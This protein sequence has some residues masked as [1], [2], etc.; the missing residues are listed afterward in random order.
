MKK[1]C[2]RIFEYK[3][4]ILPQQYV[5]VSPLVSCLVPITINNMISV[6]ISIFQAAKHYWC[7]YNATR[8]EGCG[9]YVLSRSISRNDI[10]G[11]SKVSFDSRNKS[12]F[13]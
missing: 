10:G 13:V 9:I 6:N 11:I 3:C 1:K 8:I 2:Y 4:V 7:C 5:T 12:L